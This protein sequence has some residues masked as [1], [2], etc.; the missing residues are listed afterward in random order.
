M[1]RHCPNHVDLQ[2][3]PCG[4][5]V[6]RLAYSVEEAAACLGL[7]RA[8]MYRMIAQGR[9]KPRKAGKRTLILRSDLVAFLEALPT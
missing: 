5:G 2:Q 1:A 8:H 9:L 7:S 4:Q 3:N 6:D